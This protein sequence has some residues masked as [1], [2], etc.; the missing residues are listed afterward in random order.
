MLLD[1]VSKTTGILKRNSQ[2]L[3]EKQ[4]QN[5]KENLAK[6]FSLDF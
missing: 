2:Y 4:K 6:Y 3:S 5:I 1:P